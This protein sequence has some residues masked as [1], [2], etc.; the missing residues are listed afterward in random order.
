[1]IAPCHIPN[2]ITVLRIAL[3]PFVTWL[4]L[5]ARYE[6]A[7][8]VLFFMGIT[9]AADGLLARLCQWDSTL[10]AYLDPLADK[11]MLIT[12][13]VVFG[14]LDWLPNWVVA[15]IV[16]RDAILLVGAVSFH[17]ATRRLQMEPSSISKV[18]TFFQ[19]M[20][21]LSLVYSQISPL[22]P[23]LINL[24]TAIVVC[25]TLLSGTQYVLEWS[26]RANKYLQAGS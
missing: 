7:L 8:W 13:F 12:A 25:T 22:S 24:L 2:I 1:M 5:H 21:A 20:V 19:I 17:L 23:T 6:D 18:N 10:G 14:W 4:L 15:L 9:D 3:V 16:L 11:I 26:K